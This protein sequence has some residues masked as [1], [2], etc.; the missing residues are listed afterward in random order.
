M[1]TPAPWFVALLLSPAAAN[2]Q[3]PADAPAD[4]ESGPAASGGGPAQA[5]TATDAA[6][7]AAPPTGEE[8]TPDAGSVE[9][10]GPLPAAADPG[11]APPPA[12]PDSDAAPPPAAARPPPPVPEDLPGDCPAPAART[13]EDRSARSD[14]GDAGADLDLAACWRLLGHPYPESVALARAL[15]RG[16]DPAAAAAARARLELLGGPP[17]PAGRERIDVAPDGADRPSAAGRPAVPDAPRTGIAAVLLAG[18]AGAG[19]IAGTAFG[20]AALHES[21][22]AERE[23]A[24]DTRETEYGVAAAVCLGLGLAAGIAAIVL[25]PDATTGPVPGPGEVGMGWEVR[26]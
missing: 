5:G 1:R 8:T 18:V 24:A 11:A 25:W 21:S 26:W 14:A 23:L 7:P 19:G 6:H 13:I 9:S 3:P 10:R 15:A 17:A 22:R 12:T 2:A 20:L 4:L 16:L